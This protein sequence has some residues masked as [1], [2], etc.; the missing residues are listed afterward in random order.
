VTLNEILSH[1][2]LFLEKKID[3][4]EEPLKLDGEDTAVIL[5]DGFSLREK[6]GDRIQR[7]PFKKQLTYNITKYPLIRERMLD[8]YCDLAEKMHKTTGQYNGLGLL[9]DYPL[10]L[11]EVK[12]V[13]DRG[14]LL[15]Q[16][17]FDVSEEEQARRLRETI[18]EIRYS[19]QLRYS[20]EPNLEGV[21]VIT[22]DNKQPIDV[23]NKTAQ[24][25]KDEFG[26]VASRPKI[27]TKE[28]I[29]VLIDWLNKKEKENQELSIK[30]LES[31]LRGMINADFI[32]EPNRV[33]ELIQQFNSSQDEVKLEKTF[34]LKY[35]VRIM[36]SNSAG[37]SPA[38]SSSISEKIR[39]L[40]VDDTEPVRKLI[41]ELLVELLEYKDVTEAESAEQAL[42]ILEKKKFDIVFTDNDM[43]GMSGL[44]FLAEL[45]K[46]EN[47]TPVIMLTGGGGQAVREQAIEAGAKG[48]LRK[49]AKYAEI[50]NAIEEVLQKEKVVSSPV[51]SSSEWKT[52]AKDLIRNILDFG[53]R[54]LHYVPALDT[55]SLFLIVA[56]GVSKLRLFDSKN[57]GLNS[58]KP[59]SWPMLV[60]FWAYMTHGACL[61]RVLG[62]SRQERE[63]LKAAMNTALPLAHVFTNF[64]TIFK[65]R[66]ASVKSV[67]PR[68]VNIYFTVN[69]KI[70][71]P[72]IIEMVNC[73]AGDIK[74]AMRDV[75][76]GKPANNTVSS[77][78]A[79]REFLKMI[80]S[81]FVL[82]KL[83]PEEAIAMVSKSSDGG[84]N[85]ATT[86]L[87]AKDNRDSDHYLVS[88]ST[89]S[90]SLRTSSPAR[91]VHESS[92]SPV[93]RP[94]PSM[95][96]Q[97][98]GVDSPQKPSKS[99]L[100][101]AGVIIQGV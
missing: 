51:A 71:S 61:H 49:P 19:N 87:Y 29:R 36:R 45:R 38:V 54:I 30:V 32:L 64:L 40:V 20:R 95:R 3:Y 21:Y 56:L 7:E 46:R 59:R 99:W 97:N 66:P 2:N 28:H 55:T 82:A 73:L 10:T 57:N 14:F 100:F 84:Q 67:R 78:V 26:K 43:P 101:K 34:G 91:L 92:S 98:P 11:E 83:A 77:P 65:D 47:R 89:R 76:K 88:L 96:N 69:E 18:E 9:S 70:P 85:S 31:I 23:T 81:G 90:G 53:L 74:K 13:E 86:I 79:R 17:Y 25:I 6:I 72:G 58:T 48:F 63:A 42:E 27:L 41:V 50:G 94:E 68:V 5:P 33:D 4:S 22:T 15:A 75:L 12:K 44:E 80:A 52:T 35:I 93:R 39:I 60:R 16:F 8:F 62:M 24:F 1:L 37:S